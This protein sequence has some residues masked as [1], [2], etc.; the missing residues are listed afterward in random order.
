[1]TKKQP[2]EVR[3]NHI[4]EAAIH[5]FI[6][7]GYDRA[8]VDQVAKTAGI[9]KGGVYHHF[10]NKD[11]LLMEANKKLSQPI[12]EMMKK[13]LAHRKPEEA[14]KNFVSM[15]LEH[16]IHRP[17]ELS[18]FY[19]S[20][21]KSFDSELLLT[22]YQDYLDEMVDFYQV[23]LEGVYGT[24][25]RVKAVSFMGAIDGMMNYLAVN[26]NIDSHE[27]ISEFIKI[28]MKE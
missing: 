22:Y 7:N 6:E 1:M 15:Y 25:S 2:K 4:V 24:C 5:V 27:E 3:V 21:A 23:L 9:S 8:T 16:W 18:F 12:L 14:F 20:M 11:E 19:L 17:K 28:W 26:K 13:E 10:K